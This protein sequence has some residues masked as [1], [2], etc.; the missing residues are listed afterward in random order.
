MA[1]HHRAGHIADELGRV[2]GNHGPDPSSGGHRGGQLHTVQRGD[3][4]VHRRLVLGDDLGPAARVALGD[5]VLDLRDRLL[6]GEHPRDGEEAGLEHRVN[7]SGETG[8]TGH[9]PGVDG[10]EGDPLGEEL[11]LGLAGQRVPDLRRRDRGVEQEGRTRGRPCQ[12]L[13]ALDQPGVMAADEPGLLDEVGRP[14]RVRT[15]AEVRDRLRAGL[16]GVVDEV[17]LGVTPRVLAEDLD[18]VLV[19]PDGPVRAHPEEDGAERPRRLDVE[20]A[21]V[22]EADAAHVVVDADREAGARPL[23]AQL[24]EDAGD[25]RRGQLLG[26]EPVAAADDAGHGLAGAGGERLREPAQHVEEERFAE[27]ARFLGAIQHG[28][29]ARARRDGREQLGR[30][31]R[32]IEAQLHHADLLPLRNQVSRG[33]RG[34]LRAGS[35]GDD[36]A[37]GVGGT[38]ILDEAVV[39]P[40]PLGQR[41][42]RLLHRGGH[43]RVKRVGRLARLEIDVWVLRRAADERPLRREGPAPVRADE[44]GGDERQ[45]VV[46]GEHLDRVQLV[47]GA[48]AVEEM[49]EGDPGAERRD[50]G[51]HRQVVGLLNG[52]GGEQRESGLANRH[53]VGVIAEDRERLRGQGAR[54]DVEDGRGQLTGDLVHVG[55]HQKQALRGR[56][57]G[58]QR[59]TLERAME[60]PGG[61]ALALHLHN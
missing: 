49:D 37:L 15:E 10:V 48:E 43:P 41:I 52:C 28:D 46:V 44:L 35:H 59:A 38:V 56:E 45:Q 13:G 50:L 18:G 14:D 1:G 6:L 17:P 47:G 34:G 7:P 32:A 40:G 3:R 33:L 8:L 12:H 9:P 29:A 31:E 5:G 23:G 54:R 36:D 51:H 27:G 30:R 55:D 2:R 39:A 21:V 22:R 42:H 25:H 11:F 60:R 58:G 53:H 19:C 4:C 57:G 26:G 24:G 20:G 61:T 16:L